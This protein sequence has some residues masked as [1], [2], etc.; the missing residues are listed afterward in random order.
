MSRLSASTPT[1]LFLYCRFN[2]ILN[3]FTMYEGERCKRMSRE[4]LQ[5]STLHTAY[6]FKQIEHVKVL[7]L[8]ASIKNNV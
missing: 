5:I 3:Y 2:E 4:R 6:Y 1:A 8:T 7:L